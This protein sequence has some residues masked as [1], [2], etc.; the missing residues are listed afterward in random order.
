MNRVDRSWSIGTENRILC[1]RF[2][3]IVM[4]GKCRTE[5]ATSETAGSGFVHCPV[6]SP[7][8]V[9]PLGDLRRSRREKVM[10]AA[11]SH[12]GSGATNLVN[13]IVR[14]VAVVAFMLAA[15]LVA[16]GAVVHASSSHADIQAGSCPIPG[17]CAV[18]SQTNCPS[19]GPLKP[20]P[21]QKCVSIPV[22]TFW[23]TASTASSCSVELIVKAQVPA[24]AT[25]FEAV[26]YSTIGL[27]TRWWTYPAS[28]G[29]AGAGAGPGQKITNGNASYTVPAGFYAWQV[30]GGSG[31]ASCSSANT[32]KD[33]VGDGAWNVV[34]P[35]IA[36]SGSLSIHG[37]TKNRYH[38]YFN[39]TVT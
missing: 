19:L 8:Q 26:V 21:P 31:G 5:D 28:A 12:N 27:G 29:G 24:G 15:V 33:W 7:R 38:T 17:Q 23:V 9:R 25:E 18:N 1:P 30:G 2:V 11:H 4:P 10:M 6:R 34:T 32:S 14:V 20:A 39:E 16:G 13:K 37:P 35:K 3:P 36:G 22:S